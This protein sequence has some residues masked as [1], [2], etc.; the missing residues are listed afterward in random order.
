MTTVK[1]RENEKNVFPTK[2]HRGAPHCLLSS[3]FL[4]HHE[5]QKKKEDDNI[6]GAVSHCLGIVIH[7]KRVG[8]VVLEDVHGVKVGVTGIG[9]RTAGIDRS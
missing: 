9:R 5:R 7:G 8:T 3:F 1:R 2:K 4:L 6:T